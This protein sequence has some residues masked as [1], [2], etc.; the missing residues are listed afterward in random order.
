[1]TTFNEYRKAQQILENTLYT[2]PTEKQAFLADERAIMS[3]FMYNFVGMLIGYNLIKDKQ[4]AKTYFKRD[5]KLQLPNITDE[6][7]NMSLIVKILDD[8]SAFKSQQTALQITRFLVKLKQGA[9][10]EVQG[11]ILI[12]WMTGIKDTWWSKLGSHLKVIKEEFIVDKDQYKA[13]MSLRLRAR[14]QTDLSKDFF[15]AYRGLSIDKSK[16][17][18]WN[19]DMMS[20]KYIDQR[21]ANVG[22]IVA[23]SNIPAQTP[24]VAPTAP[25]VKVSKFKRQD[26]QGSEAAVK[27][28]IDGGN[29]DEFDKVFK[30]TAAQRKESL[31]RALQTVLQEGKNEELVKYIKSI[32]DVK[33]RIATLSGFI[34]TKY[35]ISKNG[36]VVLKHLLGAQTLG[37]FDDVQ[38]ANEFNAFAHMIQNVLIGT[39]NAIINSADVSAL[40]ALQE[41]VSKLEH[42]IL[43][44]RSAYS[45]PMNTRFVFTY[46][47]TKSSD[48][49]IAALNQNLQNVNGSTVFTYSDSD[50]QWDNA[51][52]KFIMKEYNI[53]KADTENRIIA[54][55]IKTISGNSVY[56]YGYDFQR[57]LTDTYGSSPY[58]DEALKSIEKQFIQ[59]I[60]DFDD[61]KA[62]SFIKSIVSFM[63]GYEIQ[64]LTDSF[65]SAVEGFVKTRM[66]AAS[67]ENI[68]Q[69]FDSFIPMSNNRRLDVTI[70]TLINAILHTDT[71][72]N[73]FVRRIRDV[74]LIGTNDKPWANVVRLIRGDAALRQLAAT[75]FR[76]SALDFKSIDTYYQT[77]YNHISLRANAWDILN[78]DEQTKLLNDIIIG[79]S[80]MNDLAS[81]RMD[82]DSLITKVKGY[83][84]N[85]TYIQ[86]SDEAKEAYKIINKETGSLTL[87]DAEFFNIMDD[88]QLHKLGFSNVSTAVE[89]MDDD[90]KTSV[91]TRYFKN[92]DKKQAMLH[93]AE[94][95]STFQT[96]LKV[97]EYTDAF[98]DNINSVIT[99]SYDYIRRS[100]RQHV[101]CDSLA[102]INK[103][104]LKQLTSE[105]RLNIFKSTLDLIDD[106][107][108]IKKQTT[109][110]KDSVG[111][112]QEHF[113]K[114]VDQDRV[115]AQKIYDTMSY[116]M[117]MRMA[118]S[119]LTKA[120]FSA[121]VEGL[122]H[123]DESLI[124]PYDKLDK[125]RVKE[126]LQYNNVSNA[127]TKI[128]GKYTKTFDLM[129][130][131]IKDVKDNEYKINKL[132]GQKVEL[133]EQTEEE[134]DKISID[135]H[136]NKR[137][138]R[139]GVT[140]LKVLRSF[141]VSIPLQEE[142]QKT[143]NEA[144]PE[145]EIINPMFHGTGSIGASMILRYGFRVLK[146]GDSLVVGRML[147][148]GIY[149]SDVIDKAQQY[150]S[151]KG[152]DITRKFGTR[153]YMFKMNAALGTKDVDYKFAGERG[154]GNSYA[155]SPEWCVFTPNSQYKI[156]HAYEVELIGP[157]EME[158][159][160]A[161]YPQAV[162]E[163]SFKDYLNEKIE[164]T[165][166]YTT[167]T[168][169]NGIIPNGKNPEDIVDFEEWK[170]PSPKVTMEPSAY[171]PVIVVA[172]TEESK[173]YMFK[174]VTDF[175][176][177]FPKEY[178]NFLKIFN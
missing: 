62:L 139:H 106:N 78:T 110:F 145:Q 175:R 4:R 144:H 91:F 20:K 135:L 23:T 13:F 118:E 124:Q 117:R 115:Q 103:L 22:G 116:N 19:M 12:G 166:N 65:I 70:T 8:K 126:I 40:K 128:P 41:I 38:N 113:D 131:Y 89:K 167:Y 134:L 149:G 27:Y 66:G 137:N 136:N 130:E 129:D 156:Y 29:A 90:V 177:N 119:Y 15:E 32:A 18:N 147:G 80:K 163:K 11:D 158:K 169:I 98:R 33:T 111:V 28:F 67:S 73:Q 138:G 155:R 123:N 150:V 47:T 164:E 125:K 108:W 104:D 37:L 88:A 45:L 69:L 152:G 95:T 1:M 132:E 9:I 94:Q 114:I 142:S 31:L 24:A 168:F 56:G 100:K 120:G 72:F 42:G 97:N 154:T 71:S 50:F 43:P 174:S 54:Y 160:I 3:A 76:E 77:V 101:V 48:A 82:T 87:S 146:S 55:A 92:P 44:T 30:S 63:R 46:L 2:D 36:P 143:W 58:N 51:V 148:D 53:D 6:N 157:G 85:Y 140:T 122:L 64:L 162:T 151:D 5:L 161:K 68:M 49:F 133:I 165:V 59:I 172:G 109:Y 84:A 159:M 34:D 21:L 35:R 39:S 112:V 102:M 10:D 14:V 7:N 81:H 127:E 83:D 171:G 107:E 79:I 173:D 86:L 57:M 60:K 121:A 16:V 153:G 17:T 176:V 93:S 170:S 75:K 25:V 52:I 99:R 96:I 61:V 178:E 74:T 26:W 105:Q 141:K